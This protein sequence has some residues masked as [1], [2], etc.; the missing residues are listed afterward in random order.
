MQAEAA[1]RPRRAAAGAAL[2]KMR[3]IREWEGASE[4]SEL[5]RTVAAQVEVEFEC[6]ELSSEE[7][8]AVE[9][10]EGADEAWENGTEPVFVKSDREGEYDKAD[11]S[12]DGV[13]SGEYESSFIDD[14]DCSDC[15]SSDE[16][17]TVCKRL[18]GGENV[19]G[20]DEEEDDLDSEEDEEEEDD[21]EVVEEEE[22]DEEVVEEGEEDSGENADVGDGVL[23]LTDKTDCHVNAVPWASVS[24][25]VLE[26]L[27]DIFPEGMDL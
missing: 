26:P 1:P 14:E 4:S 2:D 18:C 27:P 20:E 19:K 22:D 17:W 9:A 10:R 16:E 12:D 25:P 11:A 13:E 24:L 6:E 15:C 3:A 8:M 5:F 21:E 23:P 7:R